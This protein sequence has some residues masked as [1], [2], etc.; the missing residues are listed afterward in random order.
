[1]ELPLME[2]ELLLQPDLQSLSQGLRSALRVFNHAKL[3]ILDR[4]RNDYSSGSLSEIVTCR[5]ANGRTVQLLVK[6]AQFP[7]SA[8]YRRLHDEQFVVESWSNV[9]YEADVYRH[10]LEPL[11]LSTRGFTVPTRNQLLAGCG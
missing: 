7:A 5:R 3:T 2:T 10:V 4:K 9:P 11:R 1:M 6:Y 8:C